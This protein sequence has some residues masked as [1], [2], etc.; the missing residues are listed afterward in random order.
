ML[1]SL[2][3]GLPSAM[4]QFGK[5][6]GKFE[7]TEVVEIY[8]KMLIHLDFEDCSIMDADHVIVTVSLVF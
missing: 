7:W 4:I 2:S 3:N 8:S 5:K 6:V 1:K